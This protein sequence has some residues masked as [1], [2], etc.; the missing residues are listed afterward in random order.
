MEGR[1]GLSFVTNILKLGSWSPLVIDCWASD[2]IQ[3]RSVCGIVLDN[4][5]TVSPSNM[6]IAIRAVQRVKSAF[7][8]PVTPPW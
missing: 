2:R 7:S 6:S 3:R 4:G 5:T 1:P 8:F